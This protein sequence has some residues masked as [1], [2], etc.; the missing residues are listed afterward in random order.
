MTQDKDLLFLIALKY[1]LSISV[2]SSLMKTKGCILAG[3]FVDVETEMK[4]QQRKTNNVIP[5]A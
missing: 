4:L 1:N 5:P 2:N 3:H